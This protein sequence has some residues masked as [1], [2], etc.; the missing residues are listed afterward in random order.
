MGGSTG[1]ETFFGPKEGNKEKGKTK[2]KKEKGKGRKNGRR[3]K[4]FNIWRLV[5][6][7]HLKLPYPQL[8]TD[9][10]QI[11]RPAPIQM[12][13]WAP[14]LCQ[15]PKEYLTFIIFLILSQLL[16]AFKT[17]QDYFIYKKR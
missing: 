7:P 16:I 10:G 8:L 11:S 17:S 2:G 13:G 12:G 9:L 1:R 14:W 15:S 4:R 3:L 5:R 6:S